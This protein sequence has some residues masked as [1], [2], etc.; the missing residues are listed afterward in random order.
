MEEKGNIF[1]DKKELERE[2]SDELK[3]YFKSYIKYIENFLKNFKL[4]EKDIN[5]QKVLMTQKHKKFR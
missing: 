1:A 4:T 5:I 3:A 2:Y